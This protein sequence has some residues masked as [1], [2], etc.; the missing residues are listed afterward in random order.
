MNSIKQFIPNF[1]TLLN[2]LSGCLG[3]VFVSKN[4][5][6]I[7]FL[8]I[9]IGALFDFLDGL[10]ARA[11]KVSSKLGVQLDSLSDMVTFGLLPSFFVYHKLFEISNKYVALTAFII[12]LSSAYRLGKFNLQEDEKTYFVGLPT[13]INA[14]FISSIPLTVVIASYF[15]QWSWITLVLVSAFLMHSNIKLIALKF[16]KSGFMENKEKFIFL[17]CS[18]ILIY[19]FNFEAIPLILPLYILVSVLHFNLKII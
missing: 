15:N 9:L 16:K 3:I 4:E 13:P 5:F 14:I 7:G 2:L 17:F 8:F 1:I 18:I 11:L 12:A 19:F 10:V 6:L